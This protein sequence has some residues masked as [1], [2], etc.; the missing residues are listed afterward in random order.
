MKRS[1]WAF[2]GIISTFLIFTLP[3]SSYALNDSNKLYGLILDKTSTKTYL[4]QI[5]DITGAAANYLELWSSTE[6][7]L[8]LGALAFDPVNKVLY[9]LADRTIIGKDP[10]LAKIDICT[11]EVT[12]IGTIKIE[13]VPPYFAEGLAVDP[14]GVI[15]ASVSRNNEVAVNGD[16]E[17]ETLVTI[18]PTTAAATFVAT[19]TGTQPYTKNNDSEADGLEFVGSTLYATDDPG[20]GPTYIFTIDVSTGAATYKGQLTSPRFNNVNDMAY[21]AETDKLYGFDPGANLP[22][23]PRNLCTISTI[24]EAV[25]SV[26]GEIHPEPYSEKAVTGLAWAAY[27]CCTSPPSGMVSWWP[28]EGNAKD[29]VNNNNGTI[30]G[31]TFES[32]KVGQAFSLDGVDDY[33]F[34]GNPESLQLTESVTI[35][36]WV[37]YSPDL[38]EGQV[39]SIAGK[40]GITVPTDSY[41]LSSIKQGGV[42]K[43]AM[44]IGDG[45][46][47]DPGLI[48][49]VIPVNTWTH[50]AGTYDGTTEEN[51]IY[52]NGMPVNSRPRPGGIHNSDR[53]LLI[54]AQDAVSGITRFF[55]G[56]IDEVEIFDR[57]LSLEEIQAIF[58]AGSA[59]KCKCTPAPFGLLSW[60]PGDGNANE[61]V[62]GN[63]G[64]TQGNVTFES[65]KVGQ[66]FKFDGSTGTVRFGD[67][68]D[69]IFAGADKKF[70][71]DFWT[72]VDTLPNG[73]PGKSVRADLVSKLGDS[74][75]GPEH[76]RQFALILRPTG[77]IELAFYGALDGSS[78]R[79]VGTGE[80][81]TIGNWHHI[82]VVYDGSIDTNSGLDRVSIYIN[83]VP[84]S[85]SLVINIGP[86]GDIPNGSANFAIGAAVA[87]NSDAGYFLNG[88][89]DEVEIFDRALTRAEILRIF[90]AGSSGKC[91]V[92]SLTACKFYDFNINGS[93][94]TEEDFLPGWPFTI[95]PING[96]PEPEKQY[97]DGGCVSWT[98]LAPGQY[99]ITEETPNE[100]NWVHSTQSSIQADVFA[101]YETGISFGNYCTVASDG[102][103]KGFWSNKNGQA[104]ITT[105]GDIGV[106]SALHLRAE[107]GELFQPTSAADLSTW[108]RDANATNMAYMLSA[109][110]AAMVL[111]VAH[112]FVD[113]GAFAICFQGTINELIDAA[114]E[115]LSNHGNTPAGDPWRSYQEGLK[116]CLDALNNGGLVVPVEPCPAT[117]S[118]P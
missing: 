102:R 16:Y 67:V 91:K 43:L 116:N 25:A 42:I 32:G 76:Q 41:V 35:D 73:S 96:A 7:T 47:P 63:A 77:Q 115:Q 28:G 74:V 94:E 75:V 66:A 15:Y 78:L 48:G 117:F 46:T 111:N 87:S 36:A 118:P 45:T 37:F 68:L 53:N 51:I 88:Q 71:I 93:K 54:G 2:L 5:D 84:Q 49:G 11:G 114:K 106:L 79:S 21:N 81:L 31:A 52:V 72:K 110:L 56:L 23:S 89:M 98:G 107:N 40:W 12:V 3:S 60:W 34:V 33:V 59:G 82:A 64:T 10:K 17:S 9:T 95:N 105:D 18:N 44:G 83:G 112:N 22:G 6:P 8:N 100:T 57:A 90:N 58:N 38:L 19:I 108:L 50:V 20:S 97:T 4:V 92:G 26:I 80:T 86:L 39:A 99:T 104:L 13:G 61:I 70:T 1:F 27:S 85:T 65:G 14:S 24:G 109:Q 29:I 55:P 101:T 113:G 103:S 30:N 69:D 62:N